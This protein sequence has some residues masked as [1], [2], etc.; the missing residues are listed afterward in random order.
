MKIRYFAT[1]RSLVRANE[2]IWNE[3]TGTLGELIVRLCQ[4]Y[5][6]EFNR[7]VS[8]E[9]GCFGVLSI[10]LVNGIDYRSLDGLETRLNPEDEISI[11]PPVAG[12]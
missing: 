8:K 1:L 12:G 11:F 5:G 2:E 3:P 10:F 4:K 7:W 6:S 9:E